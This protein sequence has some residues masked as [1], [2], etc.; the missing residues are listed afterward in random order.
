MANNSQLTNAKKIKDD[1]F[2]TEYSDIQKE[3]NAYI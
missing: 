2:Y 3:I 1:E